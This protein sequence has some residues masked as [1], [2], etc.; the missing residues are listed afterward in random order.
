MNE[1]KVIENIRSGLMMTV[2]VA[3]GYVPQ[4]ISEDDISDGSI[5]DI[6]NTHADSLTAV[7][8]YIK[9]GK[10]SQ[11]YKDGKKRFMPLRY[12]REITAIR[13]H[14]MKEEV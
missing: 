11:Q 4:Y 3:V 14:I 7:N 10:I 13:K 9:T 1:S 5:M 6:I 8:E 2:P 12:A